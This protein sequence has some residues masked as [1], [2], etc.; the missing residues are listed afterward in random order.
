M[1]VDV[2]FGTGFDD[3]QPRDLL[4]GFGDAAVAFQAEFFRLDADGDRPGRFGHDRH[5][6]DGFT[7]EFR[8]LLL[9]HGGEK[10]I[11]I[12]GEGAEHGMIVCWIKGLSNEG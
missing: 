12:N 2:N 6:G 3:D 8:C 11:E 9:L 7:A 4:P 1:V 5:H 10:G